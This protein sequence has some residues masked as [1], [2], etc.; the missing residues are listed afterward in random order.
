MPAW[1]RDP[2][3]QWLD[4]GA[5]RLLDRA[6]D[7]PGEWVTT[8]LANPGLRHR[9]IA[10]G[11]GVS[12]MGADNASARGG[13]GLDARTRWMRAFIRALYYQH[14]W[15]STTA[16]GHPWRRGRRGVPRS[17]GALRVRV[18]RALPVRGVIPAGREIS[19]RLEAGGA[20]AL[21]AVRGLAEADR[22]FDD[23]G[24]PSERWSDPSLRDWQ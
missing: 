12:L 13:G 10:T 14:A 19:V 1:E 9:T 2:V 16:P 17:A 24:E 15:Y 7:T 22:I 11:M 21:R 8:R 6:Y 3:S 23:G 18:G 5:R 4:G 20:S